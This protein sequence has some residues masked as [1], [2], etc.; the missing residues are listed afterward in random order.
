[1]REKAMLLRAKALLQAFTSLQ[2]PAHS[3]MFNEACCA[4]REP[5]KALRVG[6]ERGAQ[7]T[8]LRCALSVFVSASRFSSVACSVCLATRNKTEAASKAELGYP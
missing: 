5:I 7:H 6:A 8:S 2:L 4:V 3:A 1:M